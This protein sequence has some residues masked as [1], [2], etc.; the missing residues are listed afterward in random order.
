[1]PATTVL[2]SPISTSSFSR[3]SEPGTASAPR[4]SANVKKKYNIEGD[5]T[6]QDILKLDDVFIKEEERDIVELYWEG[7][8]K[9]VLKALV[10]VEKSRKAEGKNI[11]K[12]L[13]K[14]ISIIKKNLSEIEVTT[15]KRSKAVA[16]KLQKKVESLIKRIDNNN[17]SN[18][19]RSLLTLS[20]RLIRDSTFFC[21]L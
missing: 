4:I 9:A 12:D 7:I 20:I 10:N 5:I 19:S 21:S 8:L 14:R 3:F 17:I 15:K 13:R 16:Y 11:E 2:F 1:M 6:V 18:S